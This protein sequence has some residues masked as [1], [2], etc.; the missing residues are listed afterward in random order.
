M[1]E[2]LL[3]A[4]LGAYHG[5]NPAM[6]W[7][8]AVALGL[9]ERSRSAVLQALLPIAVGHE[10]SV[11]V[12]VAV[13]GVAPAVVSIQLLRGLAGAVLVGFGAWKLV[14]LGRH[15]KWV[16]FRLSKR[17]LAGWSFLMSSAHGAGLMVMPL[18]LGLFGLSSAGWGYEHG[19]EELNLVR[20]QLIE[21]SVAATVHTVS[22]LVV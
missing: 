11:A 4:A 22:M 13:L 12:I 8:F 19:R 18:L 9:Q 7:L 2:W 16:G 1:N 15:P 5:L 20:T 10:A 21:G 3:L 17:E 6:G 14:R